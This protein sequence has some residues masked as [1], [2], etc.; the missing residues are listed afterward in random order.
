MRMCFSVIVILLSQSLL[1]AE[2]DC[3]GELSSAPFCL[4]RGSAESN[5]DKGAIEAENIKTCLR[6]YLSRI[7]TGH[8]AENQQRE[9]ANQACLVDIVTSTIPEKNKSNCQK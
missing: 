2:H 1:A 5:C 9:I 4:N 8:P 6:N 3:V 7:P